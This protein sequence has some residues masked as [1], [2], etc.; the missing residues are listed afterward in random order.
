MPLTLQERNEHRARILNGLMK[1]GLKLFNYHNGEG[2]GQNW[3]LSKNGSMKNSQPGYTPVSAVVANELI[4]EG[5]IESLHRED[6]KEFFRLT[7]KGFNL[8]DPSIPPEPKA[9]EPENPITGVASGDILG[10]VSALSFSGM[11]KAELLSTALEVL[12]GMSTEEIRAILYYGLSE[13]EDDL[14]RKGKILLSAKQKL[15]L[16]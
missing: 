10:H 15:G 16:L 1:D 9:Q 3:H 13:Q 4:T 14:R 5:L 8:F 7:E 12:E 2:K 11:S 6:R